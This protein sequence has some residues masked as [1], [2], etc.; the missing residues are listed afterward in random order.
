MANNWGIGDTTL[1][2]CGVDC[3]GIFYGL[4]PVPVFGDTRHSSGMAE[5]MRIHRAYRE[6]DNHPPDKHRDQSYV[7]GYAAA[8]MWREAVERAID[9]GHS[10][11][12]GEDLKNAL[13]SFQNVVLDEM[14]AGPISFSPTD[15]RPQANES[16][17]MV[18]A[19]NGRP[20]FTF[21]DQYSIELDPKWLG[22]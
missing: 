9:A 20:A 5:M 18:S 11:P 2:V 3:A 10:R 19:A 16:V 8:L 6:K 12:T 13:E 4:F 7:Q 1:S 21:V 22:Y 14:T 15:H 17:Y